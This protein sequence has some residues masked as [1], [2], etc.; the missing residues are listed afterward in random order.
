MRN[1]MT[2]ASSSRAIVIVRLVSGRKVPIE[3]YEQYRD[4]YER[5][6]EESSLS[7]LEISLCAPTVSR[8]VGTEVQSQ[9]LVG[10]LWR[11]V[12]GKIS[13]GLS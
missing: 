5:K 9:L 13:G 2:R 1:P 6:K 7:A 10:T 11:R 12:S 3:C 4:F 8:V